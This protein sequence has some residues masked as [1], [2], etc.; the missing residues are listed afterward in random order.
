M[1]FK[2][3]ETTRPRTVLGEEEMKGRHVRWEITV[4]SLVVGET[5][6]ISIVLL[7]ISRAGTCALQRVVHFKAQAEHTWS[8][9]IY[10]NLQW[11]RE[12]GGVTS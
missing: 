7:Y 10:L 9:N 4:H 6:R 12:R 11:P 3:R 5:C 2:I 1:N 8:L